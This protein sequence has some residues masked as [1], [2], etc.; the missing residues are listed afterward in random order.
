MDA[1]AVFV[2]IEKGLTLL[3]L[4][5]Q[6]GVDIAPKVEQLIALA[7]AGSAGTLSDADIAKI[8][9]DFDTDLDQFNQPMN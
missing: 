7:K 9:A 4:L 5:I 6:A 2:L 3:P 1:A 8:R